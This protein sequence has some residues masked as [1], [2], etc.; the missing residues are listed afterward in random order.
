ME[1]NVSFPTIDDVKSL[2]FGTGKDLEPDSVRQLTEPELELIHALQISPRASWSEVG[3]ALGIDA[4]TAARRWKRLEDRGQAW[5]MG[6]SDEQ[7]GAVMYGR[8]KCNSSAILEVGAALAAAPWTFI[9]QRTDGRYDYF[10]A[11]ALASATHADAF[12]LTIAATRGVTDVAMVTLLHTF[13]DGTTWEPGVLT[14]PIPRD[15]FVEFSSERR[16]RTPLSDRDRSLIDALGRDG[17]ASFT[18]LAAAAGISEATVRRRIGAL[19]SEHRLHM[20]CDIS[21]TAAGWP[22]TML[23]MLAV[24]EDPAEFARSI[25]RR[26]ETRLVVATT[27]DHHLL[28]QFWL[29][30][31]AE[32]YALQ[33][34]LWGTGRGVRAVDTVMIT[35]QI[36]RMSRLFGPDGSA[37]GFVGFEPFTAPHPS[38]RRGMAVTDS[39]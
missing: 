8:I 23:A 15:G 29:R 35:R 37:V 7:S 1:V 34:R 22:L 18:E 12:I 39:H 19:Q 30:T 4:S 24:D 21:Q 16:R 31:P 25:V 32:G 13:H 38:P 3:H 14:S 26:S 20:R 5:V 6:Y 27:G 2:I 9:V 28:T 17:R 10:V 36:K 11:V 33:R